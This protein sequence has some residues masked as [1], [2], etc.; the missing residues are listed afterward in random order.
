MPCKQNDL[1]FNVFSNSPFGDLI[2]KY[3]ILLVSGARA[4]AFG[5]ASCSKEDRES[6]REVSLKALNSRVYNSI[7]WGSLGSHK[8]WQEQPGNRPAGA[9]RHDVSGGRSRVTEV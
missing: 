6:E 8:S 1:V 5:F 7:A 2:P 9:A 4:R 3:R